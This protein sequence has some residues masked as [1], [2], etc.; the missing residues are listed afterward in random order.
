MIFYSF[1]LFP[2]SLQPSG[3]A[4]LSKISD[5]TIQ[6]Y[7]NPIVIDEINNGKMKVR[8]GIFNMSYNWLRNMSGLAA[9][10][11]FS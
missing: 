5:F 3:A 4:N 7:L 8:V 9:P 6:F 10:A 1:S 11:F 2:K